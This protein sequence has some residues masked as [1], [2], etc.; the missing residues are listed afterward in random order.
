LGR[1]RTRGVEG[2]ASQPKNVYPNFLFSRPR[3]PIRENSWEEL[4]G[5]LLSPRL[6]KVVA[7]GTSGNG[8]LWSFAAAAFIPNVVPLTQ[9]FPGSSPLESKAMTKSSFLSGV[10]SGRRG[11]VSPV[12]LPST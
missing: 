12:S 8:M 11:I 5:Y 10:M 7:F 9:L 4:T 6:I 3:S 1:Y 2:A